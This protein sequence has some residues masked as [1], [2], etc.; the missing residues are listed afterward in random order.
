MTAYAAFLLRRHP[1]RES[2]R[3]AHLNDYASAYTTGG[4][5]RTARQNWI[6]YDKTSI[7]T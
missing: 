6:K 1:K 4:D 3:E 5:Y 7:H 2:D